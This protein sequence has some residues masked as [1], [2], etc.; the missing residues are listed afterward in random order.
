MRN[1]GKFVILTRKEYGE[2]VRKNHILKAE[3]K[4][5]RNENSNFRISEQLRKVGWGEIEA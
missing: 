1:I 3:N 4:K 2:I 5:L